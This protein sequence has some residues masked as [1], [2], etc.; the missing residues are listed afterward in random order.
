MAEKKP[1]FNY[2][3]AIKWTL[4][5]ILIAAG[6]LTKLY[7]QD[8]VYATTGIAVVLFS[9]FRVYPLMKTLK[10]EV[11]RTLNLIEIIFEF[12]LGGV[13]VYVAFS[14][15]S[16]QAIWVSLYGY[17]L[18]FVLL[19]RG[20]IYFVSLY[21]F[22]EKSE[23]MKFWSHLFFVGI[24]P[25]ILTLTLQGNDIIT[26][27][28]WLLLLVALGGAGYLGFDGYGGYKKYREK[29]KALNAEKQ[30]EQKDP[31]VEKEL[32]QPPVDEVEEK[33]TYIN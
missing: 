19:A 23:P 31:K 26:T 11:L 16:S 29:S 22:Q 32:P 13:M 27:L 30:K 2:G 4:A 15:N 1:K 9:I 24:G 14:G 28:G 8:I 7:E 25:V 17:M 20:I 18:T 5:A 33:E 21:Y 12:I 6:I 10:K 3:W